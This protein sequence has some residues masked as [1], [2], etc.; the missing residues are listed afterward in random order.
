[1]HEDTVV[2][3]TPTANPESK[4]RPEVIITTKP[5]AFRADNGVKVGKAVSRQPI[6]IEAE[7]GD[8]DEDE[9]RPPSRFSLS[10]GEEQ[11]D[12]DGMSDASLSSA[13]KRKASKASKSRAALASSKA[14]KS[15][16]RKNSDPDSDSEL[17]SDAPQPKKR[18]TAKKSPKIPK[19]RVKEYLKDPWGLKT[20]AVRRDWQEMKCPPLEMFHFDRL[21]I[22]EYTYLEGKV[23][24]LVTGLNSDHRWILSGTPP[25]EDFTS[26]NTIAAFMGIHLGVRD[27]F[28]EGQSKESLMKAKRRQKEQTSKWHLFL[29]AQRCRGALI[30]MVLSRC[31]KFSLFPRSAQPRLACSPR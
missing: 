21:V 23:Y 17:S 19:P 6:V 4:M 7:S 30:S 24:S 27:D 16:K 18:K 10:N 8:E 22:D 28:W 15:K 5:P 11:S 12:N 13:P 9:K 20:P 1:M 2:G 14:A 25:T 3:T 26:V 29:G 31:G